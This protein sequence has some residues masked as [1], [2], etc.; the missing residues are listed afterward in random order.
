MLDNL[1]QLVKEHAGSAIIDNP[2]IP[3]ERNDE[4]VSTAAGGILEGLKAQFSSGGL[5]GITQLFQGGGNVAG[6]PAVSNITN[7]VAGELMSKF[8]LDQQS[9]GNIVQQLIP[10]VMSKLVSKT[11]DPDDTSFDIGGIVQSLSGGKGLGDIGGMIGNLF[12][13]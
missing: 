11:N 8:G 12:G 6:H 3:N 1:F 5:D 10:T 13:K 2:S 7:G 9:A 4:A